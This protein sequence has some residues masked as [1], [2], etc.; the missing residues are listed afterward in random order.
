M[1]ILHIVH[2][3]LP[4]KVGGT[5]LYTRT[6]AQ[7]QAEQGHTVAIFTPAAQEPPDEYPAIEAGVQ[8]YRVM[9]GQRNP[10]A[11]FHNTF[12]QPQ[13]DAALT[14][15]IV[16]S[17]PDIVHIQHMM[18]LP[19]SLVAQI[20]A[21]NIPYIITLHDYWHVCANAQLITN[22][23]DE[24]CDGPNKYLNCARCALA[25]AGHGNALPL[26][27]PLTPLFALRNGRLR[28][29]LQGARTIITPTAFTREIHIQ[30]G[31]SAEKMQVVPHGIELPT[32][33]S[34][35]PPRKSGGD[36]L[37]VGYVGGISWQKGV[38]V[39]ITAVNQLPSAVNLTIIG[40]MDAFPNYA[41]NLRGMAR[42]DITFTGRIPH[43]ELWQMLADF[44]LVVVPT[45]WYE[46]ASLIVQEAFAAGVPV[47][48]S[49]IGVFPERVADGVDG[50]LFPTGDAAALADLLRR[51]H[52]NPQEIARLRAGI[53]P[54][55]T[56]AEH[57]AAIEKIMNNELG[58]TNNE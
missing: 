42:P 19:F 28:Q 38:H 45:L 43:A 50:L 32:T 58:T 47:V 6:L 11:V 14:A 10:T 55:F 12:R 29:I 35:M 16:H 49:R 23:S 20:R 36:G 7:Q 2:Q 22:Y 5:E 8:V 21:A 13:L 25:R 37:R 56:I 30:Q 24:I 57:V 26:V 52:N 1:R 17:P 18:G 15:V 53:Q 51:L 54:V 4:E 31:V 48:A 33:P 41:D 39:L 9:V 34:S 3:Y 46:T 44:D 27:P 40:D